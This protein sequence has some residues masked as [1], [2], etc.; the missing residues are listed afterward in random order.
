ML[1]VGLT[2][3]IGVGKSFVSGVLAELGCRVLDADETARE[4]VAIGSKGLQ[5][6][7]ATF[8][9]E[10]LTSDG[11]LDRAKLGEL[12]FADAGK[13][14]TLNSIL[15]PYIIASQDQRLREWEALDPKGIAVVDAALMIESGGYTRFDRLIVVHCREE[16]QL[17]RVMTRN[18]LS[19]EE[20]E[21]RIAA[22]MPQHEKKQ[23][24]D[25]LIDTSDGFTGARE[26][27]AEVYEKLR[28]DSAVKS[29]PPA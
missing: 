4:V 11:A 15:H 9:K 17:E 3:S 6:V 13:R 24:A 25:Y 22:Q 7:V 8:G 2:G 12:V 20:A 26:R 27:A 1:R 23:F 5:A 16:V 18:H 21:R 19:R 29:D 28:E 10:I 14:A